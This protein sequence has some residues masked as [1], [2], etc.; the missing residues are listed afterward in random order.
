MCLVV[1][2]CEVVTLITICKVENWLVDIGQISHGFQTSFGAPSMVSIFCDVPD[3]E[4][5]ADKLYIIINHI[6]ENKCAL[7]GIHSI[8][9][10]L[11][12]RFQEYR[13]GG[14]S[15]INVGGLHGG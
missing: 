5:F 9:N 3:S 10:S 8:I 11:G 2:A 15:W 4:G 1:L 12:T 13:R 7:A 6:N 14:K